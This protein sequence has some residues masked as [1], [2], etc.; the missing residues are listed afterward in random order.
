VFFYPL[1]ARILI[2]TAI[3]QDV[4]PPGGNR[5]AVIIEFIGKDVFNYA[6]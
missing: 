3:K 4:N 2:E 6:I 5:E 1:A